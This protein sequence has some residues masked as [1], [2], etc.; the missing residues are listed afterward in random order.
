MN[1]STWLSDSQAIEK[2]WGH[3]TQWTTMLPLDGKVLYIDC[4]ARTSMK[5]FPSKDEVLFVQKGTVRATIAD[6]D[7][8]TENMS[9]VRRVDMVEGSVLNIQAGCPYRLE[10]IG[11]DCIVIEMSAGNSHGCTRLIDDFGRDTNCKKADIIKAKLERL[12]NDSN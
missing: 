12:E 1:R 7:I 10:A 3:E 4:G 2:P 6:E 8:F 9:S 11:S 5:V